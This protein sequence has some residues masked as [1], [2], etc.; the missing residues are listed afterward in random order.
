MSKEKLSNYL[1]YRMT[2]VRFLSVV[3]LWPK[4]QA[5]FWYRFLPVLQL[6]AN[7]SSVLAIAMF[8]RKHINNLHRAI[9]G[10]SS[11]MSYLSNILK[12]TCVMINR[13]D[14]TKLHQMLDTQ[15][16]MLLNRPEL[17]KIILNEVTTFRRLSSMM[18]FLTYL[19][20]TIYVTR[21]VIIII[22]QHLKQRHPIR[23]GLLF[24]GIYPWKIAPNSLLYKFHYG[25]ESIS[26][27]FAFS[28]CAGIDLLFTLY[29]FQMIAQLREMSYC[30]SNIDTAKNGHKAVENCVIKYEQL[31]KCRDIL[32]KIYGPIMLW[33]MLINAASLCCQMFEFSKVG[34]IKLLNGHTGE[35][36]GFSILRYQR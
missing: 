28:V 5:R 20:C 27:I 35:F 4:D 7:I 6:T 9:K 24:P 16:F 10:M 19:S 30:I 23:Y 32:E 14:A 25:L 22:Y 31:M 29:I 33:T 26:T 11:M 13:E 18:S 36:N 12:T 3:G 2:V 34:I 17:S 1:S 15:F 21:P 8:V